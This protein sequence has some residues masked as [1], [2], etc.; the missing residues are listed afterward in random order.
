M[1]AD[2]TLIMPTRDRAELVGRSLEH[3]RSS[4]LE[5]TIVVADGSEEAD[6]T[7][8]T[9]AACEA[10]GGGLDVRHIRPGGS[11]VE[12]V[13]AA[14]EAADS[15]FVALV[16][17]DD[18][19]VPGALAEATELLAE[20]DS[21]AAVTGRA[22]TLVP[23]TA[24]P[25]DPLKFRTVNWP[26]EAYLG[27]TPEQRL[28]AYRGA[29]STFYVVRRRQAAA[30]AFASM[31]ESGFTVENDVVFMEQFDA[32]FIL[33][34]GSIA[35]LDRLLLVRSG[36]NEAAGA[37]AGRRSAFQR[38]SGPGWSARVRQLRGL[39]AESVPPQEA[40]L[41]VRELVGRDLVVRLT[42]ELEAR[43]TPPRQGQLQL[44]PEDL[45][46]LDPIVAA[47]AGE[48]R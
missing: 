12:R 45:R 38:I 47:M 42:R 14:L 19:F 16:G 39:V 15:P 5:A 7:A 22:L 10:A 37:R 41:Y 1:S 44:A 24:E 17:D 32:T 34:A 9:A 35:M 8:A 25:A 11:F 23:Q 31:A 48:R 36:S 29:T 3:Y 21:L 2:L 4:G 46:T 40:Q 27:E 18:F 26:Q 30:R 33:L 28:R 6:Q 20:E 43:P 13:S